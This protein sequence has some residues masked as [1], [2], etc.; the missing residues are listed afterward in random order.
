MVREKEESR[1]PRAGSLRPSVC[2]VFSGIAASPGVGIGPVVVLESGE[3]P[4]AERTVA[5]TAVEGEVERFRRAVRHVRDHLIRLKEN[6]EQEIGEEHS[7]IFDAHLLILKDDD[8]ITATIEGIRRERKNAEY[9]YANVVSAVVDRLDL[10]EFEHLRERA[11]DI[12]DVRSRVI[13]QLTDRHESLVSSLKKPCILV[14]RSLA[15][16]DAA[17]MS[18]DTVLGIATDLGSRTSHVA[19]MARSRGIP[20]VAGLQ[21]ISETAR[22][23]ETGVVDG[24]KGIVALCPDKKSLRQFRGRQ[25]KLVEFEKQLDTLKDLSAVTLD[26]RAIELAA[27]IEFPDEIDQAIRRGARG[28]GLYRTEFFYLSAPHLPNEEE[29][30]SA[31]KTVAEKM[32]PDPVIIRTVD[33][34]GDKFASYLGTPR[35]RNPFFGWRGIRFSLDRREVFRAQLRAIYRASDQKNVKIMFPMV[36]SIEELREAKGLCEEVRQELQSEGRAFDP[37]AEIGIMVETPAAVLIADTLARESDF[38]SIGTNDLIQYT[39]AVDR[40]NAKIAHLYEPLHPAV[41]RAIDLIVKAGHGQNIWVGIC[42]EMAADP[43]SAAI[44]V[45]LGL[46][47]LSTSPYLLPEIKTLVRSITFSEAK[48]IASM[49]L[50]LSTAGEISRLVASKLEGRIPDI[51]LP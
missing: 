48:E 9:I 29:Q 45:G 3:L 14:C 41:L 12:R 51:L 23:G 38:F 4:I 16:S 17:Q 15:P 36:S 6:L 13:R 49:C 33:L 24:N 30:L 46:D 20:A 7:K 47:E 31:Y 5:K 26:G 34:G 8:T 44:L 50:T 43:I 1:Q 21:N 2:Q 27:N 42:G 35:E 32:A 37:D 40:G 22:P 19:I 10:A 28:I 39:L 25:R 18:T 11:A